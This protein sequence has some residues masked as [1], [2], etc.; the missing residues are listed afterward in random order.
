MESTPSIS[1][2]E[3]RPMHLGS[4]ALKVERAKYFHIGIDDFIKVN[5]RIGRTMLGNDITN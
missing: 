4:L 3:R 5:S 1:W 2:K